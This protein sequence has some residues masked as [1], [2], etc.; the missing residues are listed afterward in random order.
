MRGCAVTALL[1]VAGCGAPKDAAAPVPITQE[2]GPA[3]PSE[4]ATV[5][6]PAYTPPEWATDSFYGNS[7]PTYP[8]FKP[9]VDF[10]S[11]FLLERPSDEFLRDTRYYRP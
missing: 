11:T 9:G 3:L 8:F 4:R 1:A 5:P 2:K 6:P 10:V 7:H